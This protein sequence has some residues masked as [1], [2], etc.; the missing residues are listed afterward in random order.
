M[1]VDPAMPDGAPP[2]PRHGPL[3]WLLALA[4]AGGLGLTLARALRE[5]GRHAVDPLV[6]QASVPEG[7]RPDVVVLGNS[8]ARSAVDPFEL[9]TA[10]GLPP[11]RV[12]G[13]MAPGLQAPHWLA[14]ARHQLWGRG[15]A[16]AHL[17][18]YAPSHM[19]GRVRL[20]SALDRSLLLGLLVEPDPALFEGATGEASAGW[21]LWDRDRQR[22]RDAVMRGLTY[23]PAELWYGQGRA[24]PVVEPAMADLFEGRGPAEADDAALELGVER[25]REEGVDRAADPDPGWLDELAAEGRA[26]G[27]QVWVVAA[28]GRGDRC[29][30]VPPAQA[31]AI[32]A[33][34]G[35]VLDLGAMPLPNG[36]WKTTHHLEAEGRR[37]VTAALGEALRSGRAPRGACP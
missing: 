34:G 35:R 33:A 31:A 9:A 13:V 29:P 15:L 25:T 26:A 37:R 28:A 22:A 8:V 5:T 19:L 24:E 20:G 3:R 1:P 27:T 6:E 17:V 4:L 23:G 7:A 14:I 18:V 16:P 2:P 10:L 11:D 21:A 36:A 30:T 32:E 12:V